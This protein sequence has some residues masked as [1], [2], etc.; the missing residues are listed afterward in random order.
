M[1]ISQ[2]AQR[3]H[4]MHKEFLKQTYEISEKELIMLFNNPVFRR[5]L[6]SDSWLLD[7]RKKQQIL[8][9]TRLRSSALP[10]SELG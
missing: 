1:A 9:D 2:N 3:R 5:I 4:K 8:T 10:V 7:S 6:N